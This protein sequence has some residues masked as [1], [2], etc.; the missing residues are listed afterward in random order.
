[1]LTHYQILGISRNANST[2]IKTAYRKQVRKY[3]PDLNKS[4]SAEKMFREIDNAYN[5][6]KNSKRRR[7]YDLTLGV[8]TTKIYHVKQEPRRSVFNDLVNII[9]GKDAK[10]AKKVIW[11][12]YK[13]P[14]EKEAQA[15]QTKS[16]F[17]K[18]KTNLSTALDDAL[19]QK[20]KTSS[21]FN[22]EKENLSAALDNALKQKKN[23]PSRFKVASEKYQEVSKMS[24]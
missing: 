16:R 2:Q 5:I 22:Q 13:K 17:D 7:K 14:E 8:K 9:R 21:A 20:K 3:H 4:P 19:R 15:P 12:R 6:L 10:K 1:M 11:P 18:D 24:Q 23:R